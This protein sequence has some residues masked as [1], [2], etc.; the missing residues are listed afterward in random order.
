MRQEDEA[1]GPQD[2]GK[3]Q[4]P[5]GSA[6][7]AGSKKDKYQKAQAKAEHAGE[8]LG[9]AREKLDKT[10]AKRAAKKPPGLAKKAVRGARTEAWFYVHNKI[11]EV[12]HENVGVEGAHKSELAA[13][14]GARK[15]TRYAKRRWREH[16]A[17]K[18]AKWERK[19]IKARA[20]VDFQK[21]AS[22]H[23]ELASNPLSRVQQK[24]KLKRRYSK[25]AKA[26]AKQGAKAAKKTA[27]AS[28][29]ATRRAAQFVTRHPVA[30]LVLL[31]LLLLCFLVSAVSSIFPTLGSGLAN[32]LSGTSYASEDTDLL[33]VDEDYTALENEL[34][35]T[36]ANIESTHPGYDE[37]RYSVDEIG[38][39]PYELASYL[40]A[41]YHVYF[42]EQVQDELREIFEAQYELTL[43]EE[44]EIRYRTETST[45]PETGETTTEEVPYADDF[46]VTGKSPETLRNEVMPLIK[47]FLAERGLQL[48]EEKTV[49]THISDGFDFL[50]QNVRKYN[51]KLL[52]KPSK[53]AIKSFLKKVRAIVRE[54]KTATQDLLIRKLN[55]VIRGWVNYHR[56]VVSADIFGLVDHRIFECLWRWA[57][58]RHKR[59][60]RKWIA[61]KYWHHIDNR[62]WTFAT[63]PAF[64]GKDFDEKHLKLEY[65]A[66]TKIIR[67]RK[68]AAEANPFD[69]KWTGYYEERDGE[70][71][72]N[73]TKGREKLVK[74]WNN[75]KRCCPVCGERITSETGFK[76]HF[77]TENNRKWPAIMVHP[78]CHRNLHEP[79]YLI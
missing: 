2:T 75:Q 5:E 68:I 63:E 7:K 22:E 34:A 45:D 31:L 74:I 4:E 52:I 76:T 73:S 20:N 33:G 12:E 30:V 51:G 35:Q 57:C 21:M 77:N 50:G 40:S 15:L 67:F 11:H 61:N 41:K 59:K 66:N 29:T 71:M 17:R 14:A 44:V 28:G 56:Y 43:T 38:H 32:A 47:D 48:S 23:P 37:Y 54:N 70:R 26:A 65:A 78:W 46:I 3:A 10:E 62:T 27:A 49:I 79:G 69:E 25:E 9:K 16:P 19:D 1:G 39:N 55:P 6:E 42:R 64:R 60:G 24:W 72:L 18:V 58:R 13:E 8:K 36:V 53:N